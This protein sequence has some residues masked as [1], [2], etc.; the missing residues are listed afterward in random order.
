MTLWLVS[1]RRCTLLAGLGLLALL[2]CSSDNG[3]TGPPGVVAAVTVA[4]ARDTLNVGETLLLIAIVRDGTGNV[5]PGRTVLWSSSDEVIA[6]VDAT[7]LVT[8]M[9]PGE[10]TITGVTEDKSGTALITVVTPSL[11]GPKIAFNTNRDGNDEI[12]L[13]DPDGSHLVNLT[14][15]PAT[16]IQPTWSPDGSKIAFV[17]DRDG[18]LEIYV[19]NID[20]SGLTR[21]TDHPHDDVSPSWAGSKIA[22]IRDVG[23]FPEALEIF[24]M[25]DDGSDAVNVTVDPDF[26]SAPSLSRDG[27][28][29][30]FGT[31]SDFTG[32][33][34]E[35]HV[36]N[37]DGSDP[38]NVSNH[39]TAEDVFPEWSPDGSRI[40]F[41]TDRDGN[42]EIYIIESDGSNP[43]NLTHHGGG[44]FAPAWSSDGSKIVFESQRDGN[45][46]IYSMKHDG[47][48]IQRLTSHEAVDGLPAWRP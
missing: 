26:A 27:S 31:D 9:A 28:R 19:I 41:Q 14:R 40:A 4:P 12:Y 44:D 23:F 21:L 16:D 7:G 3:P 1:H 10:V 5:L 46:E 25:N 39:D 2:A 22:F 37:A 38:I 32:F 34:S 33:L 8:G 15:H 11:E 43:V 36:I 45:T 20:R 30:A 29:I 24:V 18:N 42:F 35:I 48:G 6:S 47:S 13:M 17:S